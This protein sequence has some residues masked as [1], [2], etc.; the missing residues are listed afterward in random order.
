[1]QAIKEAV[2]VICVGIVIVI[3]ATGAAIY[4]VGMFVRNLVMQPDGTNDTD[5]PLR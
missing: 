5:R 1:M 2:G 4:L 3:A